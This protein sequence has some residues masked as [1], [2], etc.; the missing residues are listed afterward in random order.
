MATDRTLLTVVLACAVATLFHHVHNAAFLAEY[1]NMPMSLT[2]AGVYL[3]WLGANIVG[4][5]GYI[6]LRRSWRRIGTGLLVAYGCY[7]LDGLLHYLLAPVSAHTL[8][9]NVSIAAE[10]AAATAL[11]VVLF[12]RNRIRALTPNS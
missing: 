2:P 11:L 7:C 1:P 9:M 10:A 4:F 6:L 12:R 8:A 5:A 3:A